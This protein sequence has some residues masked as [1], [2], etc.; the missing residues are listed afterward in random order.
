VEAGANLTALAHET[1]RRGLAGLECCA[2][3]PGTIGAAIR[4]NAG[5]C[6][7]TVRNV[8]KEVTLLLG[9]D[10][11][12]RRE[13]EEANFGYRTSAFFHDLVVGAELEFEPAP[14]NRCRERIRE[15]LQH[16][17]TTQPLRHP[18]A[19]C[20]FRNPPGDSAGR[21]IDRAGLKGTQV[22]GARVSEVHANY[23][24]NDGQA[25]GGDFVALI[26]LVRRRVREHSGVDLEL[27]IDL[28]V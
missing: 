16:K 2:G 11:V 12:L 14:V 18:S 6:F 28:W 1:A 23:L 13:T 8:V 25:T 15:V 27:E 5:G 19:G 22:G 9:D 3:I 26:E 20:V 7:G 21:L 24:V 4:I 17:R 10:T